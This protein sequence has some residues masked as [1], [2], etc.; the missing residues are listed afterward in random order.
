MK[1]CV[2]AVYILLITAFML[3]IQDGK[4]ALA[5][6][7]P[8]IIHT[9]L[10]PV[11]TPET[12][13][14]EAPS[15]TPVAEP[16]KIPLPPLDAEFIS[17]PEKDDTPFNISVK[18]AGKE[19]LSVSWSKRKSANKY[20]VWQKREGKDKWKLIKT[21][22]NVTYN[23][24]VKTGRYYKYK[25]TAIFEKKRVIGKTEVVAVCIPD[26]ASDVIYKR[27]ASNKITISWKRGRG[28]KRFT[29]Y[30]K[31][32]NGTFKEVCAVSK[33]K[34]EDSGLAIGKKYIYKIVPMYY[35]EKVEIC[36][37]NTY[38]GVVLKDEINT[39]IQN[40]SYEE[41]RSDIKAL[42]KLYGRHF[43]YNA[44]G[45]SADGRN[46]Y[47]LVI[48]NQKANQSVI[49]VAELHAREYMT[50]QLCMKQIEYYLQNYN[51]KLYNVKVSD[52]LN[53]VAIHYVPMANPDGAAI[54]QYGFL[55]VKNVALRKKLLKMPGSNN[56]SQWKANARGVDLNRNY[57]YEYVARLGRRGSEGYTGPKK[58][59]EPETRAII[60]LVNKLRK[61]TTVRGQI[62]Y[63]A[64]GSIIFGDYEGP[65]K[66]TITD[67]YTLARSITGYSGYSGSDKEDSTGNLREFVMYKKR[68]PSI[69]LE[70]GKSFCPLP[71]YEFNGIWQKNKNLV[72]LEAELLV[73]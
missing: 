17:V 62:N 26:N 35:N 32:E 48:G 67:M 41:L 57:P 68:L 58:C 51:E 47:D 50:S 27:T 45:K 3:F 2:K 49:V 29:V 23:V 53:K 60:G 6:S 73:K 13:P 9:P 71:L 61:S 4:Q 56:P 36:G 70:I 69:T 55:A 7:E 28:A 33:A 54:S 65:L 12:T 11:E 34:Y 20:N 1:K 21:T 5:E 24:R 15:E 52:V 18:K 40:Y 31:G 44:I 14:T 72:L 66:E 63:H 39:D 10:I 46:I 43:H 38:M 19:K 64:T 25:V 59:S 16:T 30:K 42:K 22:K 37:G 8:E